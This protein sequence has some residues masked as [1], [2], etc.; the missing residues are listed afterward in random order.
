[1]ASW[2]LEQCAPMATAQRRLTPQWVPRTRMGGPGAP[3]DLDQAHLTQ[4]WLAVSDDQERGDR[5]PLL[6]PAAQRREPGRA[7]TPNC[8]R[9]HVGPAPRNAEGEQHVV[10]LGVRNGLFVITD[11]AA[12][13]AD[14]G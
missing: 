2:S 9:Q 12:Q 3:D 5:R 6:P 4:A 10:E 13:I 14:L 7:E 8:I 1:M 11:T